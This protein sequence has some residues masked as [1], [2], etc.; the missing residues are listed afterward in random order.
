M[1]YA[2]REKRGF[3]EKTLVAAKAEVIRK[4]EKTKVKWIDK[5]RHSLLFLLK[6]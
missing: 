6:I 5:A 1:F 2:Y 4:E 3:M